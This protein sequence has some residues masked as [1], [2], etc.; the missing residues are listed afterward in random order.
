MILLKHKVQEF[1]TNLVF[2]KA[3]LFFTYR[4][5]SWMGWISHPLLFLPS[6]V[7]SFMDQY[8]NLRKEICWT[9]SHGNRVKR[10]RRD[11]SCKKEKKLTEKNLRKLELETKMWSSVR[12]NLPFTFCK[13]FDWYVF[14]CS[15]RANT[16]QRYTLEIEWG[17]VVFFH[18][19]VNVIF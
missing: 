7:T 5:A 9:W 1:K 16:P 14:S 2:F 19:F 18:E 11:L 17:N 3:K 8:K 10:L 12:S 6:S 4:I 15:S 13:S